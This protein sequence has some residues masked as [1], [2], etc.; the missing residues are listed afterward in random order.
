MFAGAS[1]ALLTSILFAVEA[2]GQSNVLFPLLAACTTSYI[3]SFYLMET[4]I[5]TEKIAR[6]G[7]ITPHEY[8]PDILEKITIEQVIDANNIA[9]STENTISEIRDWLKN[10]VQTSKYFIVVTNEGKFV[11]IISQVDLYSNLHD[12]NKRIDTIIKKS[13]ALPLQSIKA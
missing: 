11:G 6:R 2:T 7:I 10:N 1:R 9:L 8:E 13:Y 5:M 12:Q 4:T 3:V